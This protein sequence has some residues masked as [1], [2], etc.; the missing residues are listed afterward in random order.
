MDGEATGTTIGR[1]RIPSLYEAAPAVTVA[2][3]ASPAAAAQRN[4]E[5]APDGIVRVATPAASAAR[6]RERARARAAAGRTAIDRSRSSSERTSGE[7][8]A[9]D[10]ITGRLLP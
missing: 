3:Q 4:A 5:R 7:S 2:M 8:F 6:A 1:A 9:D 10:Q